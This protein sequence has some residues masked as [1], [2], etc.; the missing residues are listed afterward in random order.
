MPITSKTVFSSMVTTPCGEDKQ[1]TTEKHVKL[2]LK[3]HKKKCDRC[4]C[5]SIITEDGG[6]ILYDVRNSAGVSGQTFIAQM[7]RANDLAR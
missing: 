4:R 3:L 2:W 6:N 7:V 5:L 1:F